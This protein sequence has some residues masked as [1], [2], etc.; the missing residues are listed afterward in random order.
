MREDRGR[1][2]ASRPVLLG[3]VAVLALGVGAAA[4]ADERSA[5]A[6]VPAALEAAYKK[7]YAFLEAEKR[8]LQQRLVQL[9]AAGEKKLRGAR[10]EIEGLQRDLLARK[11][12]ADRLEHD[13]Q[14]ADRLALR[15]DED[16]DKL[17]EILDRAAESLARAGLQT[18]EPPAAIDQQRVWIKGLFERALELMAR[19]GALRRDSGPFFLEDGSR[20]VG[21]RIHLGRV[22]TFGVA[23]AAAGPLAPAGAGRLKLWPA[24][25]ETAESAARALAAGEAPASLPLFL[26]ESLDEAIEPKASKSAAEVIAEGGVIAWVIVGIG[27]L[28]LLMI[29]ARIVILLRAGWGGE[30]LVSHLVA[31]IAAGKRDAAWMACIR[32]RS[33]SGRV[34]AAAVGNLDAER[35]QLEDRVA[36]AI[37]QRQPGIERF[38]ASITVFAAVAPLLGLLG[39][40]TGIIATFDVITEFGTGDPKLL[41]GGISEALVTTELG[42]MVAIPTLLIGTLLSGRAQSLLAGM[43]RGA[44]A[45]INAAESPSDGA[46]PA[47]AAAGPDTGGGE[48]DRGPPA[49]VGR[50]QP[51]TVQVRGGGGAA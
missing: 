21:R 41:S 42:L 22:A 39:T 36:E 47:A 31:L 48:Q 8:A 1:W 13:L 10:R 17:D 37:L 16:A 32:S 26:Y 33:A 12:E 2:M 9:A 15:A 38:G 51:V 35:Q 28:A 3:G 4:R 45:V 14:Q 23:E 27:A 5:G 30:K 25:G 6:D 7:E 49:P 20:I 50:P 46:A 34:L 44:L 11:D 40:V 43:E 24:A 19:G 29:L 18:S